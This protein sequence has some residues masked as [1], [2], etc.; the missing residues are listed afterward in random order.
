[1]TRTQGLEPDRAPKGVLVPV[2]THTL[3]FIDGRR[4]HRRGVQIR[5][6]GLAL[7]D[8]VLEALRWTQ[9][10]MEPAVK[11][12]M[13]HNVHRKSLSTTGRGVALLRQRPSQR[14]SGGGNYI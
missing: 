5:P 9:E 2:P 6:N 13:R 12:S 11:R 3:Q 7:L 8:E 14:G 1:M 10:D 4:G